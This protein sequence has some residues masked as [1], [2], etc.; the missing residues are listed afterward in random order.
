MS[1]WHWWS[2]LH[3]NI[4]ETFSLGQQIIVHDQC[5]WIIIFYHC[6]VTP[7][8]KVNFRLSTSLKLQDAMKTLLV[9]LGVVSH[10]IQVIQILILCM[11]EQNHHKKTWVFQQHKGDSKTTIKFTEWVL[12]TKKKLNSALCLKNNRVQCKTIIIV[13]INVTVC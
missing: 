12:P 2:V 4:T 6:N 13:A 3:L 1:W 10:Q 7:Q 8:V 9:T 11:F 5:Q